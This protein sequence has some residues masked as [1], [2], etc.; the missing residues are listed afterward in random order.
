MSSVRGT[1]RRWV[2]GRV[3][4]WF[5]PSF[6][7]P[8]AG[9]EARAGIDPRRA[10]SVLAWAL[11]QDVVEAGD[12]FEAPEVGFGPLRRVH[13]DA[14]LERLDDRRVVARVITC[15]ERIVPVAPMMEFWRRG[16]GASVDGFAWALAHR[17]RAVSLNGGFHHAWPDRGAGFCA[18]NDV[19]VAISEARLAGFEGRVAI[20]D[21]DAHPPD[22]IAACLAGD[23]RVHI[24]SLAAEGAWDEVPGIVDTR[25]PAGTTDAAYLAAL[26]ALLAACPPCDALIYLAG[27]DPL[28][29]D[30]FGALAVSEAGLRERDRRVFHHF[31]SV[32]ALV[33]PAGGYTPAAWR[34]YAGTLAEA[35]HASVVVAPQYDPLLY[36]TRQIA[37]QLD[38][39]TLAGTTEGWL[40]DA[41]LALTLGQ[42]PAAET[43]FLGHYT[44]PG[45]EYALTRFGLLDALARMGFEGVLIEVRAGAMPHQLWVTAEVNGERARLV[46]LSL[47]FRTI[48]DYKTL[49]VE[50]LAMQDPRAPSARTARSCPAKRP[51]GWAS[52]PRRASC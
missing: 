15:D 44:A 12:V 41:D 50:W 30:R 51:Q 47:S 20:I 33:L 49:F 10:E 14:W 19:A 7:V 26:D 1:L 35:A 40:D 24:L 25:L 8:I 42:A 45:I 9:V 31:P 46:D 34:V 5:H 22:G 36:R 52:P 29:G 3:G 17:A 37:R 48:H 27:A 38:P 39:H 32:P 4:V 16:V 28:V 6:R 11:H 13:T 23:E 2:K 21:L 18:L 43:R